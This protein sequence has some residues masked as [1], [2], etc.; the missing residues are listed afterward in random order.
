MLVKAIQCLV[1]TKFRHESKF[2]TLSISVK[3]KGTQIHINFVKF[4]DTIQFP[5]GTILKA[6][7]PESSFSTAKL[8]LIKPIKKPDLTIGIS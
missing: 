8:G 2:V 5:G 1:P 7:N 3:N 6:T 4:L